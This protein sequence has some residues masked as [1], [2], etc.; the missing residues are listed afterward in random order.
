MVRGVDQVH[1]GMGGVLVVLHPH[2]VRVLPGAA[3]EPPLPGRGGPA[4]LPPRHRPTVLRR[5]PRPPHLPHRLQPRLHRPPVFLPFSLVIN[6][7][8]EVLRDKSLITSLT[9]MCSI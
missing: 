6:I 2:G 7:Q 8:L 9:Y 1:T 3:E 5:L 4:H